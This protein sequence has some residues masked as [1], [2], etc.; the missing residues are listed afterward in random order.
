MT[1]L[2]TFSA[3]DWRQPLWLLLALQPLLL[4]GLR[5]LRR[6][7]QL[8][9]FAD[10]GLLPWVAASRKSRLRR[11]LV[12]RQAFYFLAWLLLG[13]AAA[14]PRL[15]LEV[16][17]RPAGG[18]P[19]ILALVDLSRSMAA[20]DVAPNRLQ[21]ARLELD[22]LLTHAPEAR[23]G[24]LVYAGQPHLFV[25]VTADHAALRFY[26]D[27][28]DSL[29]LPT[30]GS[31]L[32]EALL[33]AQAELQG[34]PGPA[35]LLLI[36]DGDLGTL[37][38]A[39]RARLE[40]TV[41]RL[42][43]ANLRLYILGIGSVEGEAIPL[44]GGG[45]LKEAGQP[46]ISRLQE[47]LL[48]ELARLGGGTYHLVSDD[49]SDWQ[50]LYDEGLARLTAPDT[51]HLDSSQVI[52]REY[53]PWFL[54]PGLLLLFGTL[55]PWPVPRWR[56]R[57][58]VAM[59]LLATT[60]GLVPVQENRAADTAA[61]QQA[62]RAFVQQD[63]AAA[64]KIY[65][66][67][68]GYPGRF[69]AGASLYRLGDATAAVQQF[70][71]AVLA[72][73]TEAQ[74]AAALYNLGNSYFRIG[75]YARAAELFRDALGYR[76]DYPAARHNLALSETLR[77]EVRARLAAATATTRRAGR[78]PRR[79]GAE[80]GIVLD[81]STLVSLGDSSEPPAPDLPLPAAPADDNPELALLIEKGLARARLAASG[82]SPQADGSRRQQDLETV[83]QV[84]NALEDQPARPWIRLFEIEEGFPAPVQ[85]RRPR[86]GSKPW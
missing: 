32:S 62:Y 48:Q 31:R 39:E 12:S 51:R 5:A 77:D 66:R 13:A 21:R 55:M 18:G 53:Y 60:L 79:A 78:G 11:L 59:L 33:M 46:V 1:L 81:E 42:R 20:T 56:H 22:E 7:H 63:Y 86:P 74:R 4:P 36:T 85:E 70:S 29:D 54:L 35:G 47:P 71:Q 82:Q 38:A 67:L 17:G 10:P 83:R 73:R 72:A 69:G 25:P 52:W 43:E 61:E 27:L 8:R 65:K 26:L 58:D 40:H 44:P 6:R 45:W 41:R 24:L 30:A 34:K 2:Q 80:A 15:A 49:A 76:P 28:L 14:G 19:D 64:L 9:H 3:L 75:D 57:P 50:A 68:A 23:L 84:M 16:P 37:S